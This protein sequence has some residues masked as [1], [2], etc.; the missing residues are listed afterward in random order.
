[1]KKNIMKIIAIIIIS[2]LIVYI[3]VVSKAGFIDDIIDAASGFINSKNDE[4]VVN[5]VNETQIV[6][7]SHEIYNLLM[8]AGLIVA[9][10]VILILGIQIMTGSIEQKAKAKEM[11]IPFVIGCVVVFGSLTIWRMVSE[12]ATSIS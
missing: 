4:S 3:P 11:L 12:V 2:A 8:Y 1:M 7:T 6:E 10:G 9:S 5:S